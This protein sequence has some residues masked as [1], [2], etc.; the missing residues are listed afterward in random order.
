MFIPAELAARIT[1]SLSIRA[2]SIGAGTDCSA[3][4]LVLHNVVGLTQGRKLRFVR[5][6]VEVLDLLQ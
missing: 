3:K 2:V 1:P 6:F 5:T 4:V